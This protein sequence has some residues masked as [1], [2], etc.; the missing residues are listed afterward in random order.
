MNNQQLRKMAQEAID[1]ASFDAETD[2]GGAIKRGLDYLALAGE[3]EPG[4]IDARLE[5]DSDWDGL[6]EW[7]K[8]L[9]Q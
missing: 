9:G 2:P 3:W 7:A 8:Y 5:G 1:N 6:E 4:V